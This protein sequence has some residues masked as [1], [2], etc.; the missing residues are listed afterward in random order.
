MKRLLRRFAPRND[1]IILLEK[2][3]AGLSPPPFLKTRIVIASEAT[4]Q[5][6]QNNF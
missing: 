3:A 5:L 2:L 4:K 6:E 1:N